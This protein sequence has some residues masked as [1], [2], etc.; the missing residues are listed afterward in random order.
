MFFY[1]IFYFVKRKIYAF[2]F[3][4]SII[5][6]MFLFFDQ[7]NSECMI[8]L[9]HDTN[10]FMNKECFEC[11][12][13]FFYNIF[14]FQSDDNEENGA[15]SSLSYSHGLIYEDEKRS[16]SSLNRQTT[17]RQIIVPTFIHLGNQRFTTA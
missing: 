13:R 15:Y 5:V 9:K 8:E 3:L 6:I 17:S 11:S 4:L 12:N 2:I 1:S 10:A 7:R 16:I 14:S